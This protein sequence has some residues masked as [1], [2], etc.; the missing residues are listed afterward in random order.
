MLQR[1]VRALRLDHVSVFS[2]DVRELAAAVP[3]SFDVVTARSF[4]A[5]HV[6]VRWAGELLTVGGVLI[7]SEPPTPDDERWPAPV[8]AAAGL[9]DLG[10]FGGVRRFQRVDGQ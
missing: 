10:P 1:A 6:T 3:H 4:A 7:V 5:P 2:G 9:S 8:L